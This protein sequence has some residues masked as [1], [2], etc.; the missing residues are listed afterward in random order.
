MEENKYPSPLEMAKNLV[1]EVATNVSSMLDGNDLE[2]T[3]ENAN[4]RL[5]I[6][7]S[8]EFFDHTQERCTKCGCFMKL[9]AKLLAAKC[10]L[11]K[12]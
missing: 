12:W 1:S 7:L 4:K 3:P 8:C 11:E 5:D 9:K 2:T 10:P 6:C